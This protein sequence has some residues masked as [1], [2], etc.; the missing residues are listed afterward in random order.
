MKLGMVEKDKQPSLEILNLFEKVRVAY[1]SA[2]QDPQEYGGR[3]RKA[4]EMIE[5]VYEDLDAAGK[6]IKNYVTIKDLKD[7]EVNNPESSS[8]KTLYDNIKIL[9]YA[10]DLVEDPFAKRFKYD[11]LDE[12]LSNP[13]TMVKF[14]HYALRADDKALPDE[15]YEI[16]D[17]NP[18]KLRRDLRDLT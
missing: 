5:E 7:E 12:L 13:E 6:E 1:L 3:W 4:V 9:R 17:M 16:K 2:R 11:V 10:S 15:V 8:A 14:V 18:M